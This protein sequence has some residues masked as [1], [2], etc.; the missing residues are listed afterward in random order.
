MMIWGF[1]GKT[2]AW[3]KNI[4]FFES[5][6]LAKDRFPFRRAKL[7][8][9]RRVCWMT[10]QSTT[11]G[12]LGK[13]HAQTNITLPGLMKTNVHLLCVLIMSVTAYIP[14]EQDCAE[15]MM[16]CRA[17]GLQVFITVIVTSSFFFILLFRFIGLVLDI[18]YSRHRLHFS[19]NSA[20][21]NS[22]EMEMA[23]EVV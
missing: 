2:R 16:N 12:F 5:I 19:W 6:V 21:S 11:Q 3:A 18:H 20:P 23:R 1:P 22:E 9:P 15:W 8:S 13:I 10:W 4:L 7:G 17:Y 14:V